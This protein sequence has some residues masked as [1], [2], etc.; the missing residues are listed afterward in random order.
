MDVLEHL[1][2]NGFDTRGVAVYVY[3]YANV[4]KLAYRYIQQG[5]SSPEVFVSFC[6]GFNSPWS[7]RCSFENVGTSQGHTQGGII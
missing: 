4:L 2:H 6:W 7:N 5:M 1:N 3:A